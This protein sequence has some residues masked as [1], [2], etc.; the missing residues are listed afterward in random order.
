MH[1]TTQF[2]SA[3]DKKQT[4]RTELPLCIMQSRNVTGA[5]NPV[6][7]THRSIDGGQNDPTV[8]PAWVEDQ[9]D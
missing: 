2:D 5:L 7:E 3:Y 9:D 1:N 4:N 6:F 8:C